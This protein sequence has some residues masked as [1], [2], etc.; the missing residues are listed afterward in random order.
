MLRKE[1]ETLATQ[2]GD[3]LDLRFVVDKGSRTWS[4]PTG[5]VTA[6]MISQLFPYHDGNNKVM[7]FVCGP[8]P[9][10]KSICGPKDGPRQGEIQG[11]LKDLGYTQEEVFKF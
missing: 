8:P 2:H 10:V 6:P 4:G 1:W 5:F 3:R 9:Q 7:A 11:A